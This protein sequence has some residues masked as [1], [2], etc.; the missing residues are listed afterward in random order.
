M[1]NKHASSHGI[2]P[3]TIRDSAESFAETIANETISDDIT[4]Q[5]LDHL[6][7]YRNKHGD[8][9]IHIVCY[10]GLID[11]LWV[12]LSHGIS[13]NIRNHVGAKIIVNSLLLFS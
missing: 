13:P 4:L 3:P 8:A 9:A 2:E 11:L 7:S 1:G 12:M 5:E 10:L 6:S